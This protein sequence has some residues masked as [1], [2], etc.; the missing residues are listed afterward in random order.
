MVDFSDQISAFLALFRALFGDFDM[1]EVLQN[2][3][4]YTNIVMYVAY[5]FTAVFVMLSMFFAILGE[6]QANVREDQR[7]RRKHGEVE[8]SEYGIFASAVDFYRKHLLYNL[9][10]V[11]ARLKESAEAKKKAA[12]D[13]LVDSS[14]P[15]AVDRIE[16]RQLQMQDRIE[17]TFKVF[18]QR[19]ENV[20]AKVDAM[21]NSYAHMQQQLIVLVADSSHRSKRR[22][23]KGDMS[24]PNE[25]PSPG[26]LKDRPS[27][28][29][30]GRGAGAISP[31]CGLQAAS[32]HSPGNERAAMNANTGNGAS[33]DANATHKPVGDEQSD[34][35]GCAVSF[36]RGAAAGADL[37]A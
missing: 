17:D 15:S 7:G 10:G 37:S 2:S 34:S 31:Q 24:T 16:A 4:S 36:G 29:R 19:L 1:D 27:S 8:A 30:V 13:A 21:T 12:L 20:D 18:V 26:I 32:G 22:R 14:G 11:G 5:L 28:R 25:T 23:R 3:N 33:R 6:S 35:R 9:P